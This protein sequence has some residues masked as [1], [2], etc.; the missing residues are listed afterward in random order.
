MLLHQKMKKYRKNG[1]KNESTIEKQEESHKNI[2]IP[3]D[4]IKIDLCELTFNKKG[5]CT[6]ITKTELN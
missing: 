3:T 5:V 6:K 1:K 2:K 4:T